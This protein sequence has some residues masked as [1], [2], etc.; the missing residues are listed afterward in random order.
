LSGPPLTAKTKS[1]RLPVKGYKIAQSLIRTYGSQ[2][3]RVI[4]AV[5]DGTP[6]GTRSIYLCW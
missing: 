4:M 5:C 2:R 1:I 6:S 3:M